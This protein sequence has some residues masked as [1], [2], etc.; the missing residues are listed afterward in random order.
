M[1]ENKTKEHFNNIAK[2]YKEEIPDHTRDHLINKFW[3]LTSYCFSNNCKVIDIGCGDGTNIAFFG[4]KGVN[5]VG[6]DVSEKLIKRGKQRYPQLQNVI[7]EGNAL[8]LQFQDNTFDVAIM[9]G[10]LH[11]IYS[12]SDQTRAVREALRVVRD[13]GAVII[14][15]SN[16]I[17]P[18]F[19]I[20]W[21]Y[22]FPLTA[23]I[24]RFGGENWIS[25][26]KLS[27]LF[28]ETIEKTFYFTF[29]P[30][31]TPQVLIPLASRVEAFL[32]NSPFKKI[33]AHYAVVLKKQKS[34]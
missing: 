1:V 24:D 2:N 22:I 17:N 14:R 10:V 9:I 13:N 20:F 28:N 4:S 27:G 19:R 25:P 31:F 11:H 33:S 5:A 34:P 18:L 32:E 8:N 15:E 6:V 3:S 30:N 16:L 12:K 23:K 21:N 26:Q 7:F 29:I